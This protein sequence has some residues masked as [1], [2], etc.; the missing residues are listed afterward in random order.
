[1]RN[2]NDDGVA[3]D[4]VTIAMTVLT[5]RPFSPAAKRLV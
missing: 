1:M 5:G 3:I 4:G 2:M